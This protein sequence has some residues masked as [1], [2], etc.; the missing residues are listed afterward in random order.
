MASAA[1]VDILALY[2]VQ[3]PRVLE[4]LDRHGMEVM[5]ARDKHGNTGDAEEWKMTAFSSLVRTLCRRRK[6]ENCFRTNSLRS[7]AD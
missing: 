6:T 7:T 4:A 3:V 5:Y 2:V 1:G